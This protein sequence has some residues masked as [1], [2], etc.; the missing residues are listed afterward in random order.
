MPIF[1]IAGLQTAGTAG[2]VPANLAELDAAAAEAKASGAELLITPE[3]FVTGYDIGVD[4]VAKLAEGDLARQVGRIAKRHGIALLVGLPEI[5]GGGIVNA[6]VLLDHNG[7]RLISHS[8]THLFGDLDRS[9]F[10]PGHEAVSLV[11][12]AGIKIAVLICY[13]VEFPENVRAAALAGAQLIAVPTAQMEPFRFVADQ[14]IRVRAWENQ[15]YVAYINHIGNEGLTRYVGGSSICAPDGSVVAHADRE[16]AL[17]ISD[18]DTSIVA[19]GQRDN[20]Y[21]QDLRSEM[22][23]R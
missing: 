10:I 8:K 13:D 7:N 2:D 19:K 12:F 4:L 20:P 5:S 22:F 23:Q 17:I 3:M 6:A 9:T 11:E 18:I 1:R 15:V 14:V 21:L 16:A